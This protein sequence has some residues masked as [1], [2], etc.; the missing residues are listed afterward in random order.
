MH[1]CEALVSAYVSTG[2]EKYLNR[3]L[4]IAEMMTKKLSADS[5]GWVW[6]HYD[7][8]WNVDW[9]YNR[10]NPKHLFRPWGFQPGH[11]LEWAKLCVLLHNYAPDSSWL[12]PTAQSLFDNTVAVAWDEENGGL[13]Y[14]LSTDRCTV[15]DDDKYYW[16][17]AEG[18]AAALLLWSATKEVRYV[19]VDKMLNISTL[20]SLKIL[21]IFKISKLVRNVV[22]LLMETFHRSYLRCMVPHPYSL[23]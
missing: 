10:S 2:D 23:E 18:V 15:C 9:E 16:V 4:L 8:S 11:Q 3:S 13:F 21:I 22:E 19:S 14:S 12:L 5:C 6:E 7:E 17:Q 20:H 1:M